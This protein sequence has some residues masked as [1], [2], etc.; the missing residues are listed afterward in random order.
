[1][2]LIIPQALWHPFVS[3]ITITSPS[4]KLQ[5]LKSRKRS[6]PKMSQGL[7]E[8]DKETQIKDTLRHVHHDEH[9]SCNPHNIP[10]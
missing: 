8:K 9:L 7:R 5:Q 4:D 1:M 3:S 10:S 6:K 2:L